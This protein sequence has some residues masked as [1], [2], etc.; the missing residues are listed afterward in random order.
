MTTD[1]IPQLVAHRGDMRQH[2]EN[3]WPA[4]RAAVEAGACW[5]E[6]DVQMC[7]DGKFVLLHDADFQRTAGNTQCVFELDAESCRN[8]SVHYPDTFA[9]RFNP[10]PTP[11]L[12][13]VLEWLSTLPGVRAMVE[14]KSESL[15]H[16]GREVVMRALLEALSKY[17]AQCVL[18][19]FDEIALQFSAK[20]TSL[21]IGWVVYQYDDAHRQRAEHLKPHYLICNQRK[22]PQGEPLWPGDW[23]WML[24]DILEPEQALD[25]AQQGIDLIETGDITRLL[26]HP[27]LAKRSCRYGL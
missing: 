20:H 23:R 10:A 2:P 6:F 16:F 12:D 21:E 1:N 15:E 19:S 14:I 13:E 8:I 27:L 3:S 4:L 24:Y 11:L 26:K 22:I 9:D 5:L 25:W 18:I 17:H 7:A